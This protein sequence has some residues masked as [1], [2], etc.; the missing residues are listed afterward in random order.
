MTEGL[1]TKQQKKRGHRLFRIPSMQHAMSVCH[2][3][4]QVLPEAELDAAAC[5]CASTHKHSFTETHKR[6]HML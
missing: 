2:T 3:V 6:L 5:L 4:P 1:K